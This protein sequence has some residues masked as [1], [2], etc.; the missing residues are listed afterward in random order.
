LE[1]D[2]TD[3]ISRREFA[4]REQ[5][6][7]S[8]VRKALQKGRLRALPCG[9]LDAALVG[10][11]WQ[12]RLRTPSPKRAN[13]REQGAHQTGTRVV[14]L[15]AEPTIDLAELADKIDVIAAALYALFEKHGIDICTGQVALYHLMLFH[16]ALLKTSP[17]DKEIVVDAELWDACEVAAIETAGITGNI[18]VFTAVLRDQLANHAAWASRG[19][20]KH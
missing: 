17:G 3:K 16:V 9:K 11:G 19:L 10:T 13:V 1:T 14:R 18:A 5:C 12:P 7:E 8:H 15:P 6:S 2:L 20:L 4:R